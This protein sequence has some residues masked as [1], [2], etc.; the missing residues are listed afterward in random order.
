MKRLNVRKTATPSRL[1]VVWEPDSK[2]DPV[3]L[4][5]AFAMIFRR[6]RSRGVRGELDK[7]LGSANVQGKG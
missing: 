7:S 5:Q 4:E 6:D 3:A 2:P 1:G